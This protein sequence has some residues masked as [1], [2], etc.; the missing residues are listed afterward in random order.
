MSLNEHQKDY[1]RYL[2]SLPPEEKCGCGWYT[3]QECRH[4]CSK[5][6]QRPEDKLYMQAYQE[7]RKDALNRA[8]RLVDSGIRDHL[9]Y[10]K[11]A[12][13][14]LQG[15]HKSAILVLNAIRNRIGNSGY[16]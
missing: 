9:D 8:L 13:P 11:T 14:E 10:A 6:S 4:I 16:V 1:V 3:T 7:G 2:D 12:P 5:A 15:Y